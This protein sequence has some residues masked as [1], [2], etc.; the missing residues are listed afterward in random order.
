[1]DQG[2]SAMLEKVLSNASDVIKVVERKNA[3]FCNVRFHCQLG[4]KLGAYV[5]CDRNRGNVRVAHL[6]TTNVHL[7][8]LLR[9]ANDQEFGLVIVQL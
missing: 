7:C 6:S 2:I 9:G 1:M 5:P 8:Q 4:I 3:C